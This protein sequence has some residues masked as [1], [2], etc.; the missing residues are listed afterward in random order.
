MK[1]SA[2]IGGQWMNEWRKF[3]YSPEHK[4][5]GFPPFST[6]EIESPHSYFLLLYRQVCGITVVKKRI[7]FV[8]LLSIVLYVT[9]NCIIC[10]EIT[11]SSLFIYDRRRLCWMKSIM[12]IINCE[13]T[14]NECFD[15]V[16]ILI[17]IRVKDD[18]CYTK[19]N[20]FDK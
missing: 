10:K 12:C 3:N 7:D 1:N 14:E 11:F 4:S 9:I 16:S 6:H 2:D 20:W 19:W 17:R 15:H 5:I 8:K 13:T 18:D